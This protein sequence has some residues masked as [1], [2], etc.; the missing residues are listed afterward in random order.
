MQ[1]NSKLPTFVRRVI[2]EHLLL[3]LAGILS[4]LVF[5][6]HLTYRGQFTESVAL[7]TVLP[8]VVLLAGGVL[9]RRTLALHAEIETELV[10]VSRHVDGH[11]ILVRPLPSGGELADGWNRISQRLSQLASCDRLVQRLSQ[12]TGSRGQKWDDVLIALPDGIAIADRSSCIQQI[13][14]S[15]LAMLQLDAD[16]APGMRVEEVLRQNFGE[17]NPRLDSELRSS[18][19]RVALE[20]RSGESVSDGVLRVNR[21]QLDDVGEQSVWCFRDLTPQK[22][23]E[24]ARNQFVL[25][26]THELR[27]PLSNI[28]AL[29]ETLAF[30]DDIDVEEHKR[31]CNHINAEATRLAR[32]V[33]ELL[34]LSQL[35][36]GALQI[37]TSDVDLERLIS[38]TLE[39]VRPELVQK[40]IQ[41]ETVLP[42]KY[43]RIQLDKDKIAGALVNLLGNAAKYTPSGGRVQ[44]KIEFDLDHLMIE[45]EDSGYGISAEELP[46]VFEKF[47]RS[48]DERVRS[49]SGSGLG[50]AF[51]YEVVRKHGGQLTATSELDKGSRFT[52][53]LPL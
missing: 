41:F 8:I 5:A 26:A 24:E 47:Y 29:A 48:D 23:A 9:L 50:L 17:N 31:F 14:P 25:T 34:D 3:G 21:I 28:R 42:A 2:C 10:S 35:E 12:S 37:S 49:M 1:G 7:T 16:Q 43:P 20:L 18:A 32:F 52:I 22:L 40:Q 38:D 27:T 19:R 33:D 13:N 45:V 15:A 51:T 11:Q 46:R 6:L 53:Q 30:E 44:L 39:H 4:L 36:A